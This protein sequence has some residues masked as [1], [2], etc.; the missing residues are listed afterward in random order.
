[1]ERSTLPIRSRRKRCSSRRP[2]DARLGRSC[3]VG[4]HDDVGID[5]YGA[6]ESGHGALQYDCASDIVRC[7]DISQILDVQIEQPGDALHRDATL[8]DRKPKHLH[9]G[10]RERDGRSVPCASEGRR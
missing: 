1:M 3:L 4:F 2:L 9:E 7:E 6:L 5:Q 10:P 8:L